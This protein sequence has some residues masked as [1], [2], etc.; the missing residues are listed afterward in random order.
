MAETGVNP[1]FEFR[2]SARYGGREVLRDVSGRIDAG[3]IVAL[4]GLSGS[5][6]STLALSLLRLLRYRGG[7]ATGSIRLEGAELARCSDREMRAVL[8][9]RIG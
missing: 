9:K 8:G 3:E 4:V 1:V 5:G 2:V 7:E 6:K